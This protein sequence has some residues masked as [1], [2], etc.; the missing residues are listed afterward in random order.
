M[1]E[2]FRIG[3]NQE[4]APAQHRHLIGALEL[5]AEA[6]GLEFAFRQAPLAS[7][8][9][10]GRKDGLATLLVQ[11]PVGPAQEVNGGGFAFAESGNE[12]CRAHATENYEG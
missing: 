1:L 6:F 12:L 10:E 5:A 3:E 2:I 11:E 7:L 9:R 4:S 8:R